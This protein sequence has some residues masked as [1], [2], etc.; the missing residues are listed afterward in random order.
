[1]VANDGFLTEFNVINE[2][3]VS[4]YAHINHRGNHYSCK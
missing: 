1:M 3:D 4:N 2:L